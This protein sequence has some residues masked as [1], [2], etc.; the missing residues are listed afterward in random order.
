MPNNQLCFIFLHWNQSCFL[1]KTTSK[2][3]MTPVVILYE[4]NSLLPSFEAPG[5]VEYMLISRISIQCLKMF[6]VEVKN[7]LWLLPFMNLRNEE[8]EKMMVVVGEE[9]EK[10]AKVDCL[11]GWCFQVAPKPWLDQLAIETLFFAWRF[12]EVYWN[13]TKSTASVASM[14]CKCSYIICIQII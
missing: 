14:S 8:V 5:M 12:P 7:L 13:S 4:L 10:T 3:S 1:C 9:S 2:P 6:A 11:K